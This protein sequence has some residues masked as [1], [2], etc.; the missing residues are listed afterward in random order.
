M[1]KSGL[2]LFGTKGLFF[3][4]STR[5]YKIAS[6]GTP[7]T[8]AHYACILGRVDLLDCLFQCN[9]S[10]T[11]EVTDNAGN[12]VAPLDVAVRNGHAAC[13]EFLVSEKV[14]KSTRISGEI[15]SIA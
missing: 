7:A 15:C 9:M 1:E 12:C 5:Q 8:F 11:T 10:V 6:N 4:K 3:D 14:Q 2:G 13:M